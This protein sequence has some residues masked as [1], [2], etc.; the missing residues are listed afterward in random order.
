ME[1]ARLEKLYSEKIRGQLQTELG[2]GSVMQVPQLIKI[3]INVGVK[4]AISD[5]KVL[6]YAQDVITTIAGQKAIRR[7]ARKSIAG[8]KLREGMPIGVMV[9][10]RGKL[11]YEF[12][13]RLITLALP[14]IRDFQGVPRKFDGR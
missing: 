14:R 10:L 2:L 3:V 7:K 13:D 1:K 12:L 8:F 5:S 4:D 6:Q 9:T 11:M